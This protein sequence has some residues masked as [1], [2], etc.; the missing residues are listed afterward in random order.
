MTGHQTFSSNTPDTDAN[1]RPKC[2]YRSA[3]GLWAPLVCQREKGHTG[4][5]IDFRPNASIGFGPLAEKKPDA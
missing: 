3:T 4:V 2:G 5:H 1:P